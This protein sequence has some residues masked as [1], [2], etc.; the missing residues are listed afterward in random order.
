MKY[1]MERSRKRIIREEKMFKEFTF[2]LVWI[3]RGRVSLL[4]P[5][6]VGESIKV[7]MRPITGI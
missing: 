1:G 3:A 5:I 6:I 7:K 2:E 4:L